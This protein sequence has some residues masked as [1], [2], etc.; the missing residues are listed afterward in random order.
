MFAALQVA[1][2]AGDFTLSAILGPGLGHMQ[3]SWESCWVIEERALNTRSGA[4][5]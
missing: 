4:V 5:G 3:I 1:L 2:S